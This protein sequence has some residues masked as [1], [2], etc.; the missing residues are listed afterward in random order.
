MSKQERS[1]MSYSVN[2]R[3]AIA[4][5]VFEDSPTLRR[6]LETSTETGNKNEDNNF[7]INR[8][9]DTDAL[10]PEIK[11]T[12]SRT[13]KG[14]INRGDCTAAGLDIAI[15]IWIFGEKHCWLMYEIDESKGKA[16]FKKKFTV[17][18]NLAMQDYVEIELHACGTKP[19]FE[20]PDMNIKNKEDLNE[21]ILNNQT[22]GMAAYPNYI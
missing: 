17:K 20:F 15:P 2:H 3:N 7:A 5:Q 4:S 6:L 12:E 21:K 1:F 8:E 10:V 22:V 13:L 19:I 16:V 11:M 9:L 14:Y 18:W